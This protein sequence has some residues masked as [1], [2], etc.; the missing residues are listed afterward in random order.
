MSAA[1]PFSFPSNDGSDRA[2][3]SSDA[4]SAAR[5]PLTVVIPTLNE[6]AQIAQAIAD[7]AW[8]DEVIVVDGGSTDDTVSLAQCAGAHVLVVT[9][10]TIAG[11]RNAGIE[12]ARNQWVLALDADER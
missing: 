5:L 4:K 7:V 2:R 1:V 8:A 3:E 12:A 10:T 11:Q 9:G 6:S